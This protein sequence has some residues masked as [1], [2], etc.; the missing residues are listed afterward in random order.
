MSDT[1]DVE[2]PTSGTVVVQDGDVHDVRESPAVFDQCWCTDGRH[3]RYFWGRGLSYGRTHVEP[4]SIGIQKFEL[5]WE[6]K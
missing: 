1:K 4:H 3:A 2:V 5:V 6:V